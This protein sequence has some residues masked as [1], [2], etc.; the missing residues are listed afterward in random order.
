MLSKLIWTKCTHTDREPHTNT[1][2][3]PNGIHI[4]PAARESRVPEERTFLS[5]IFKA[6][7]RARLHSL[8]SQVI[9]FIVS[10]HTTHVGLWE[11]SLCVTSKPRYAPATAALVCRAVVLNPQAAHQVG[12]IQT[13]QAVPVDGLEWTSCVLF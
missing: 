1:R 11:G 2:L 8:R 5:G 9:G 10:P 6:S 13:S 7:L 12:T 4:Y 3:L